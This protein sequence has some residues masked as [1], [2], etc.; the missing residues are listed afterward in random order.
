MPP[1]TAK[2][3]TALGVRR[4]RSWWGG[5][6]HMPEGFPSYLAQLATKVHKDAQKIKFSSQVAKFAGK[7]GI[8]LKIIFRIKDFLVR[9]IVF[10]I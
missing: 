8:D 4:P 10:E 5:G 9:F 6:V 7:I 1:E 3:E 2:E